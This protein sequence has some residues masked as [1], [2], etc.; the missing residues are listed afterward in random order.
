MAENDTSAG[1][2]PQPE[3]QAPPPEPAV[4]LADL[5][6]VAELAGAGARLLR[7]ET[8]LSVDALTRATAYGVLAG[9]LLG[10]AFIALLLALAFQLR[11][12][13]GGWVPALL[14]LAVLQIALALLMGRLRAQWRARV[15][16]T[17]TRAFVDELV[18][19]R[20]DRPADGPPP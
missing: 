1:A 8:A 20:G 5:K 6:A 13:L 17:H 4:S 19:R 18:Q 11:A 2:G 12:W 3:P 10:G 16:F 9:L 14:A 7:A 15:G